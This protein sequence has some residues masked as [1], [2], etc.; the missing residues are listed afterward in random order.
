MITMMLM[1]MMVMMEMTALTLPVRV[2]MMIKTAVMMFIQRNG[3]HTQSGVW[4]RDFVLW[5]TGSQDLRV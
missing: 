1:L 5:W 3:F 2:T 4:S